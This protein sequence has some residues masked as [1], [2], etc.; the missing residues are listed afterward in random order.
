M[1]IRFVCLTKVI[2]KLCHLLNPTGSFL[3][4]CLSTGILATFDGIRPERRNQF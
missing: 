3:I 4:A 1:S 2:S